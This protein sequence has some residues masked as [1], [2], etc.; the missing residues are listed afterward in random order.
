MTTGSG[1]EKFTLEFT[2]RDKFKGIDDKLVFISGHSDTEDEIREGLVKKLKLGLIEYIKKS[3]LSN[4]INISFTK[5]LDPTKTKDKWNSWV[6]NLS[7]GGWFSGETSYSSKNLRYSGSADRVTP[8]S[9]IRLSYYSGR[10]TSSFKINEEETIK[11]ESRSIFLEGVF[12]LSLNKHWSFGIFTDYFSSTYRNTDMGF[13]LSPGIEFNVF[14]YSEATKKQFRFKYAIGYNNIK[15]IEE[16]IYNKKKES[17]YFQSLSAALELKQKWG[18]ITTSIS[19]FAYLHDFNKYSAS[20]R[21]N[22]S[23][24]I[25]KGLSFE[26]GSG[27][28]VIHN[29]LYLAKGELTNEEILLRVSALKTS[30]DYWGSVGLRFTF[31][32]VYNNVVNPRFGY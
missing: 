29:Q 2:G 18:S 19:W 9:R 7:M 11:S 8:G 6:F 3:G 25:I 20:I 24:R 10:Y 1:G 32:S 23:W 14:P 12:V 21:S 13:K 17:L 28:S 30:Y 27:Y 16:T 22:V 31:G 15:Y 5:K 26:M 4:Y